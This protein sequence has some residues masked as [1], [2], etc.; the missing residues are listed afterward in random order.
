M[1]LFGVGLVLGMWLMYPVTLHWRKLIFPFPT[2]MN[3]N[4]LLVRGGTLQL[5]L[6]FSAVHRFLIA[7]QYL[8]LDNKG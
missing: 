2:G 7:I 5:P 6:L 8:I 4:T 3:A 1:N